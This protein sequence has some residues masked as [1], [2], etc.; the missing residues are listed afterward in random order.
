[1]WK[2]NPLGVT[3]R[4]VVKKIDFLRSKVFWLKTKSRAVTY[5]GSWEC[6]VQNFYMF[7]DASYEAFHEK[8]SVETSDELFQ[9]QSSVQEFTRACLVVS[10]CGNVQS[11][12]QS[13]LLDDFKSLEC[14]V[15]HKSPVF[16]VRET[17]VNVDYFFVGF[18]VY[19]FHKR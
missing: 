17:S 14:D 13:A 12:E 18:D 1:M 7:N 15:R 11:Q 2:W 8:V 19:F 4:G 3:H 6:K 16:G 9:I 5:R 10:V